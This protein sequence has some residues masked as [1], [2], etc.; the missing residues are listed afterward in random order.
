MIMKPIADL[1]FGARLG[2]E[3]IR[4]R[5]MMM[6]I[7]ASYAML[8][9]FYFISLRGLALSRNMIAMIVTN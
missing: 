5:S 2:S 4:R 1:F 6:T 8:V 7:T 3:Q 9:K